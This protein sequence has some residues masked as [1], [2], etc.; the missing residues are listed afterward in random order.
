MKPP[1]VHLAVFD[2]R[3]QGFRL[4]GGRQPLNETN[5]RRDPVTSEFGEAFDGLR[6]SQEFASEVWKLRAAGAV[7][8]RVSAL[9]D[10]ALNDAVKLEAIVKTGAHKLANTRDV[11]GANAG[12]ISMTT[13]PAGKSMT[14]MFSGSMERHASAGAF[15]MYSLGRTTS[16]AARAA[17]PD[18]ASATMAEDRK[19]NFFIFTP[20]QLS[21]G[22]GARLV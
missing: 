5:P 2:K 18:R 21:G 4:H 13:G 14:S 7:A 3:P 20:R 6:I 1:G 11:V 8:V 12:Y 10:K 19:R 9:R 15:S 22:S 16:S 17:A